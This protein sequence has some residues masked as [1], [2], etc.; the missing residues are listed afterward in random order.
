M[1]EEVSWAEISISV[2][3]ALSLVYLQEDPFKFAH[4]NFYAPGGPRSG[5]PVCSCLSL[6]W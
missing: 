5:S 2:G 6:S 4:G 1:A 3:P